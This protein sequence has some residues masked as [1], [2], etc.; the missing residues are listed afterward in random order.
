M[1]LMPSTAKWL[2]VPD[3]FSARDNVFGGAKYLSLLLHDFDGDLELAL[4]AYNAGPDRV[5]RLNRVPHHRE[6]RVY[7]KRVMAYYGVIKQLTKP[8]EI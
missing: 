4:A 5:R 3:P 1:Q 2:G 6:T 8:E 7:V